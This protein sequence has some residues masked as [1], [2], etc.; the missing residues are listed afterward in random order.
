MADTEPMRRF[1]VGFSIVLVSIVAMTVITGCQP[2]P[3]VTPSP[4]DAGNLLPPGGELS[5]DGQTLAPGTQRKQTVTLPAGLYEFQ[6]RGTGS[7]T[8]TLQAGAAKRTFRAT[9]ESGLYGLLFERSEAGGIELTLSLQ[10]AATDR[11]QVTSVALVPADAAR[12]AAWAEAKKSFALLGYYGTD[13]QR[14][15][16]GTLPRVT[17]ASFSEADL[18]RWAIRETVVFHDPTYDAVWVENDADVAAYF[19]RRGLPSKNAVET[20]A[21]LKARATGNK[22]VGSSIIFTMG[23]VPTTIV[24]P[25]FTDCL[26]AKYLRAGG[27]VVWLANVPMYVAQGEKGP[28]QFYG[29]DASEQMLGLTTD[30][31]SFYGLQTNPEITAAGRAWG[32]EPGLTLTRPVHARSVTIPF[33]TDPSGDY[34]G[35]GL[36]NLRADLPLSG[37]IFVPDWARPNNTA[38]LANA[39]RLARYSG[40]PV[41]VPPPAPPSPTS[42][43]VEARLRFGESDQRMVY[44]RGETVP[45]FLRSRALRPNVRELHVRYSLSEGKRRFRDGTITIP[46][47][48]EETDQLLGQLVLHELRVGRYTVSAVIECDGR[49]QTLTRELRIGPPPDHRGTHVAV[50]CNTSPKVNRTEFLLDDLAAHNLD[51]MFVA[52]DEP[53]GRDLA[54]WYGFSFSSRQHG[55]PTVIPNPPGYDDYR[56]GS[57]G[58]VMRVRAHGDKREARGYSSPHRR[59][60]EA[61]D[62]AKHVA[63]DA[64]FPS[65][66][67]RTVTGDDYSQWFGLDYNRFAV[68][69]FRARYG[70]DPPRPPGT[71]DPHGTVNVDRAPEIIPDDDPW[72]RLNRYWSET[73]G[74]MGSRMSRAM[75]SV[76]EGAGKV[77][78]VPGGMQQPVMTLGSAQYPPFNFG[79]TNGFNLSSFYYYNSYWQPPLVHLWWLECARMG[80]RDIEQWMMPDCYQFEVESF[81]RNNLWLIFAGGAHG[82]PHFCYE[83]R[84]AAPMRAMKTFGAW[85]RRYGLLLEQLRPAPKQVAMLVP[86]ENITYRIEHCFEMA[87]AFMNL[88]LAK[89]DVEPVSPE[90]L[91][92]TSIRRYQ[93]IVLAQTKWLKAGTVKL[94]EDY[95]AAG[96]KVVLDS[97]TAAAIPVKGATVLDFPL[98]EPGNGHYGLTNHIARVRSAILPINPPP[99][100]CADPFVAVRRAAL[101]D[102]TPGVWLVHNYTQEQFAKLQANKAAAPDAARALET[103]LGYRQTTIA[104][105]LTRPDDGRIPF[106]VFGG[107]ELQAT[108]ADG[109]MTVN[110]ELPQW[111][112]MLII[113]LPA[114]PRSIATSGFPASTMHGAPVQLDITLHDAN[115]KP[116][117]MPWPLQLTVRDPHG[118]VNREYSR[119]LLSVDGLATHRIAFAVNDT[120]GKWTIEIEDVLAG[121][122]SVCHLHLK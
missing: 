3:P 20:E 78:P 118:E 95:I 111:E 14:P 86:F 103:Q 48:H 38:L 52:E 2:S 101:P 102:G 81:Y 93:T 32:L 26:L 7:G 17:P 72:I 97:V 34:C 58:Q 55:L 114:M 57:T 4:A 46:L 105:T 107:R 120:P 65:F 98:G 10:G 6:V 40:A 100:D 116:V 76:T 83:Q 89:V 106:D 119:R 112:G 110:V 59:Q 113:F 24:Y 75:K 88:L 79:A 80:N 43:P 25:P 39:W 122:K 47:Q 92:A 15:A 36:V 8:L 115:G 84:K 45:L 108:R 62:F 29:T 21:W 35:V 85:S 77:G 63:F 27:R 74:D 50:W 41:D 56:L 16:P 19:T 53:V 61:D 18:K 104:T 121:T 91:D 13:P 28:V 31:Q 73:L 37:F 49:S 5:A 99:V 9:T 68:E 51:P 54:L 69:G 70:I 42:V 71:E 96:G 1:A 12:Q 30:R 44:L 66:R 94:L 82:L 109:R 87:F 64:K 67:R 117:T 23:V 90:E 11:F 60:A 33:V 22:G